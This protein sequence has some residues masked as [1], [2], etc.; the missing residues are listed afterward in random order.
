VSVLMDVMRDNN[1]K[2][3]LGAIDCMCLLAEQVCCWHMPRPAC[4]GAATHW[5]ACGRW[6][7][8]ASTTWTR[9]CRRLSSAWVIRRYALLA[10]CTRVYVCVAVAVGAAVAV[11]VW[12]TLALEACDDEWFRVFTP[13][14]AALVQARVRQR[15]VDLAMLLMGLAD[16]ASVIDKLRAASKHKSA[17][18]REQVR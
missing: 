8:L 17:K 1:F 14:P 13:T 12:C 3:G 6:T 11:C 10:V 2:L 18:V 16:P 5:D 9:S 7:R 15:A 4:R